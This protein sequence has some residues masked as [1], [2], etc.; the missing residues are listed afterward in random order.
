MAPPRRKRLLTVPM[1]EGNMLEFIYEDFQHFISSLL[2][3]LQ[4]YHGE[5]R[6]SRK[7]STPQFGHT[8]NSIHLYQFLFSNVFEIKNE[9]EADVLI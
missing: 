8:E 7:W 9:H 1:L 3:T 6:G 4:H 2:C 5:D